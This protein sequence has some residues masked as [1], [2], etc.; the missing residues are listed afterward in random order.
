MSSTDEGKSS[1]AFWAI[2]ALLMTYA[3]ALF[4]GLPQQWTAAVVAS[5]A[6]H[7]AHTD[8]THDESHAAGGHEA[9]HAEA[10]VAEA[11]APPL[12]TIAPFIALLGAIAVFPLLH[13]TEHWWENNLNRFKVAVGLGL[14]TLAY[15]A[16]LHHSP[17]ESHWP[18]H[19]EVHAVDSVVQT[20]FVKAILGNALL[21]EYIPFIVLLFSLYTIAGGIRIEGDL[22]ADPLTNAGFMAAGGVLASFIG[23]TGAAMLLIRPLLETNRER[24]FVS[25]TVVFFIFIVCNCGG[26][27]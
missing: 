19:A 22:R 23:T 26:C 7:V 20:G 27:P 18:A 11:T 13:A 8:A 2:V 4:Y 3:T 10:A 12:W 14:L 24:K 9:A 15:Y 16:F 5:H 21:Q 1:P 17:I 6:A 25:H